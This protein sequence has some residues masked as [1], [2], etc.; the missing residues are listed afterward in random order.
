MLVP[1]SPFAKNAN[2]IPSHQVCSAAD[3]GGVFVLFCRTQ[4]FVLWAF[5]GEGM[6]GGCQMIRPLNRFFTAPSPFNP[7][8]KDE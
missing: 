3:T 6:G 8:K 4:K 2:H 5:Y 7:S 1:A